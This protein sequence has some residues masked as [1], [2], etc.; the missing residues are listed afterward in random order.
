MEDYRV[1]ALLVRC[2]KMTDENVITAAYTWTAEELIAA[3]ENAARANC[4]RLYRMGLV[5]MALMGIVCGWCCYLLEGWSILTV[6]LPLGGLYVLLWKFVKRFILRR[7]FKRRPD[8]NAEIV[9]TLR[10][11]DLHMKSSDT[12]GQTNWSQIARARKARNGFLLYPNE[13]VFHWLP[14]HAFSNEIQREAAE[15]LLREKV[16]DFK[17]I[18]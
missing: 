4:R 12:D 15:T 11:D 6:L 8:K 16:K 17:D 10:N 3:C 5:F 18:T 13:A 14:C 7:Q 9:W 1:F 2:K